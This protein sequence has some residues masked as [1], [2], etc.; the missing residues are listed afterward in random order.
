[1]NKLLIALGVVVVLAFMAFGWY[2]SGYNQMISLNQQ[3]KSSWAQVENQLQRRMDLIPNLVNTVKGYAAHEKG[4]L[5]EVTRLRSQ[6]G[7]TANVADKMAVSNSLTGALSHLLMVSENY[8]NLKAN[9]NFLELQSQLEG[10]ENRIA[11]ERMRYNQAVQAFNAY[12]QSLFGSFFASVT[13]LTEPAVYFK[14]PQAAEQAPK[15]SF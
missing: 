13:H 15:V 12:Q 3:V 8:P 6:W 2:Q 11:V 5:E 14:A 9:E 1:M 4:V 10:T 7:K